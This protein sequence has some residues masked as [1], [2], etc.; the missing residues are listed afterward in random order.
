MA[1]ELADAEAIVVRSATFV[2]DA[3]ME[4]APK[5]LGRA[6]LDFFDPLQTKPPYLTAK[7]QPTLRQLAPYLMRPDYQVTL[8]VWAPTPS[9]SA[10]KRTLDVA[11]GVAGEIR[12]S[13]PSSGNSPIMPVSQTWYAA[14]H[15]RPAFSLILSRVERSLDKN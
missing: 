7:H 14:E 1:R 12:A 3:M 6:S 11:V 2:D 4:K 8:V 5:L 9:E 13:L 15:Q 10:M